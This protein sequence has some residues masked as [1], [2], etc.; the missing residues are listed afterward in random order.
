MSQYHEDAPEESE[1]LDQLETNRSLTESDLADPLDQ[2]YA[3]PDHWSPAEGYGNTAEEQH[4]GESLEQRLTQEVPDVEVDDDLPEPQSLD[5]DTTPQDQVDPDLVDPG[6]DL[7][8][9][10]EVG[11]DR[12]GRL[13]STSGGEGSGGLDDEAE[14]LA[15]DVGIDGAGASAEEAAVRIVEDEVTTL[16]DEEI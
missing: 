14:L 11:E 6:L 1:Q 4:D 2:G 13:T 9:G 3:A 5:S 12:A 7:T 10:S 8:G 15:A 16:S